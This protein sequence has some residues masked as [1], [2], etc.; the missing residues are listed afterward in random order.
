[1]TDTDVLTLDDAAKFASKHAGEEIT[2]GD[3]LRAAARGEIMLRAIVHRES[4]LK[5]HD[6]GIY[7][8][9]GEPT[10]NTVPQG[11]IPTLPLSACQQLANAGRA[12]WRTFDGFELMDGVLM[13]FDV[14]TLTESEPDFETVPADCRVLGHDVHALADEYLDTPAPVAD[15]EQIEPMNKTQAKLSKIVDALESY[16]EDAKLPFDRQAMPGP[17]GETWHEEGSFHWLCANMDPAFKRAPETFKKHRAGIC[18]LMP[19]ADKTNFYR[20]ALSHIAP[21][22]SAATKAMKSKNN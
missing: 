1:M 14:A 5:K 10:E 19:Y 4:K 17:L 7:C 21:I 11:A 12:S 16:A 6:G 3:F 15:G 20:L 2:V 18:A 9:K 22:S 8:N 13:R